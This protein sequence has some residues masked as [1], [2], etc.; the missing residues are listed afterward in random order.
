[1]YS[2]E[3]DRLKIEV[4]SKGAELGSL[5]SKDTGTE[6][7]WSGDATY[8]A[9]KSPVLFP[10]VGTLKD[11]TYIY[12]NNSYKLTRHG[13]ARDM[14]F[15][16]TGQSDVSL[17]MTLESTEE[18]L[19]KFPFPF[20]LDIIYSLE[21][22]RLHVDYHVSGTGGDNM[23][24]SIGAHPAFKIPLEEGLIYE[25]YYFEFEQNENA[26][27]WLISGEGLINPAAVPILTDSKKLP[28]TRD[29]FTKDAVVL[30]HLNSEK[31]Y[32]KSDKSTHGVEFDFP[33]FPFLGLWTAKGGNFVCIEPWC[34]IADSTTT[35]QDFVN[36]EGINLLTPG[37]IFKRRWSVRIF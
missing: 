36:K 11:D 20:K 14:D 30:K 8:W 22:D 21:N 31:V 29:L 6:Y 9:K 12:N 2:L 32:L 15:T 34:G 18:T 33:R 27:R 25:D 7:L 16:K 10:I 17:T 4:S 35:N 13:F 26:L 19:A 5:V 23:Y 37:E 3:N 24:F 28:V 1:M